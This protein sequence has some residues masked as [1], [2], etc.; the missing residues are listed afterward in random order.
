MNLIFHNWAYQHLYDIQKAHL[1]YFAL[2]TIISSHIHP[3]IRLWFRYFYFDQ[4]IVCNETFEKCNIYVIKG[5]ILILEMKHI[6]LNYGNVRS[7]HSVFASVELVKSQRMDQ[8]MRMNYNTVSTFMRGSQP[9]MVKYF[10]ALRI[11]PVWP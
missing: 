10:Y 11:F 3:F 6:N 7:L 9:I 1:S 2:I 4:F 5:I 8:N